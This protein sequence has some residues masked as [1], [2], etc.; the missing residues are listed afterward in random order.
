MV[1][2]VL[3]SIV[4]SLV[5]PLEGWN[6]TP[7]HLVFWWWWRTGSTTLAQ[8]LPKMLQHKNSNFDSMQVASITCSFH[9]RS[10]LVC[11]NL[12]AASEPE[13]AAQKN[14]WQTVTSYHSNQHILERVPFSFH[15]HSVSSWW[16]FILATEVSRRLP[17]V[18]RPAW[19]RHEINKQNRDACSYEW[20]IAWVQSPADS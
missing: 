2:G 16:T 11:N 5:V 3:A 4:F 10:Q 20:L 18:C 19:L 9:A 7:L 1:W 12:Q 14:R 15:Y 17:M 8:N 6:A 13:S